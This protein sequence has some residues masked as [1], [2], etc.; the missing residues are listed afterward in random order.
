MK[1]SMKIY[2]GIGDEGKTRLLG[3]AEV[4]KDHLRLQVYGTLDELNSF[5]GLII[6]YGSTDPTK[7]KLIAIQNDIFRISAYL[8]TP[9]P[10][11]YDLQP[12][13]REEDIR[14]LEKWIDQTETELEPLKNFILPGGC[15]A[16]A[17]LHVAR[18]VCRRAERH[19]A[20][21]NRE[22]VM[23]KDILIY[24]NRLSDLL[25]VLARF[26][27]KETGEADV[28]WRNR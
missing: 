17:G 26:E 16:S 11:K 23:T 8:A 12:A 24:L 19:L 9:E 28:I 3:G 6:S 14:Q 18:T 21:L 1:V 20:T 13:V 22:F 25:F 27:N 15:S 10:E 2:T 5:I 7:Q 4:E